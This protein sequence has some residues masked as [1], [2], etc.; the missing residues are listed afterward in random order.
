VRNAALSIGP[1]GERSAPRAR[2]YRGY[3]TE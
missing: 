2:G 3:V 1:P